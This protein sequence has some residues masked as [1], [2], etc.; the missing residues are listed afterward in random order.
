MT[1]CLLDKGKAL[2][3]VDSLLERDLRDRGIVVSS[4][5]DAVASYSSLLRLPISL[6][7][8]R[9]ATHVVGLLDRLAIGERI[10]KGNSKLDNVGSSRLHREH[11][12]HGGSGRREASGEEGDE[13]GR[14]LLEQPG[15]VS[16]KRGGRSSGGRRTIAAFAAKVSLR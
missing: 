9:D 6:S 2:D 8:R 1:P 13:D 3:V 7:N 11:E 16:G 15:P 5:F 14:V 4:A 10:R 12:R